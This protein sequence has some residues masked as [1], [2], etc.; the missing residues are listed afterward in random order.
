[1]K[2]EMWTKSNTDRR[3]FIGGSDARTIM[4]N[5]EA[6]LLRLWQEKRGEIDPEDLDSNI[7][8]VE[9]RREPGRTGKRAMKSLTS[10]HFALARHPQ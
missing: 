7:D 4:G 6:A 10:A 9:A 5:D 8:T 2:F 3:Y 1:M